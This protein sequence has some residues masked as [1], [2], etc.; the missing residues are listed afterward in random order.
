VDLKLKLH[1]EDVWATALIVRALAE[2]VSRTVILLLK[3]RSST[4]A[5]VAPPIPE[6][7]PTS[8]PEPV[9]SAGVG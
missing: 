4:R 7:A 2:V 3:H 6:P 5:R 8:A 1:A 9:T